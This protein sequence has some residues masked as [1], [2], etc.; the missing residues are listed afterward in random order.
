MSGFLKHL[1]GMAMGRTPPGSAHLLLPS[2]FERPI[3]SGS[4][5]LNPGGS[6]LVLMTP[7]PSASTPRTSQFHWKL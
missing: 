7:T 2:R 6:V 4:G 5:S 1:V 3:S